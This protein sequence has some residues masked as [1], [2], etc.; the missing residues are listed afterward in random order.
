M[1]KHRKKATLK[2]VWIEWSAFRIRFATDVRV[3][4]EVKSGYCVGVHQHRAGSAIWYKMIA[5]YYCLP[6]L[7]YSSTA[8]PFRRIICVYREVLLQWLWWWEV[9]WLRGALR[10]FHTR[11]F[12]HESGE[13]S[14]C[15]PYWSLCH[16]TMFQ[17]DLLYWKHTK[18]NRGTLL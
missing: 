14:W 3:W 2:L 11:Q 6:W 4:F 7:L 10:V 13:F 8:S 9:W 1:N 17:A 5:D 18:F 16:F 12:G 15:K